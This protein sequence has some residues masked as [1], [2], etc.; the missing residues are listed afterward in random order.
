MG[1]TGCCNK[2]E[3][4]KYHQHPREFLAHIDF[5]HGLYKEIGVGPVQ[6]AQG[7]SIPSPRGPLRPG[8]AVTYGEPKVDSPAKF[9]T[10]K[11]R[12]RECPF[13]SHSARERS[14]CWQAPPGQ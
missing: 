2:S 9:D 6:V 5:S 4:R 1:I 10:A 13:E 14:A 12:N 8:A 3:N 7:V 11:R